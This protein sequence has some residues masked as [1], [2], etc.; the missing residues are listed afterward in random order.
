MGA[1]D[2]KMLFFFFFFSFCSV[3]E[4]HI[5][6]SQLG[7]ELQG[8]LRWLVLLGQIERLAPEYAAA[9]RSK[10]KV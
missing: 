5:D 1:K 8:P 9:F 4:L 6:A 10:T 3:N 7:A 2:R